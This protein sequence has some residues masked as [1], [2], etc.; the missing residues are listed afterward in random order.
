MTISGPIETPYG[1]DV[2]KPRQEGGRPAV[3]QNVVD[4]A[5]RARYKLYLDKISK[6]REAGIENITEQLTYEKIGD[7]GSLQAKFSK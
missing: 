3:N 5:N 6:A 2:S 4:R 1:E 7:F